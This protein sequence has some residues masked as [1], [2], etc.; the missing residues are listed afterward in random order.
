M[1]E[2]LIKK[3]RLSSIDECVSKNW[4]TKIEEIN[5]KTIKWYEEK[6]EILE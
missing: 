3:G 1:N 4:L 6:L 2:I 5:E